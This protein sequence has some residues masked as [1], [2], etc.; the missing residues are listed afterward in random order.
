MGPAWVFV[1][2]VCVEGKPLGD[3]VE[4]GPLVG[5]ALKGVDFDD[6]GI[7]VHR[8]GDRTAVDQE[9]AGK[10]A[11]LKGR[12]SEIDH[13]EEGVGDAAGREQD[14]CRLRKS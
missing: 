10:V 4:A 7:G 14:P 6:E 1:Q 2:V 3:G 8:R 13:A 12:D 5:S 11:S 9:E